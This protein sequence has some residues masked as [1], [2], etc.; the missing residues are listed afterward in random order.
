MVNDLERPIKGSV[1]LTNLVTT[2]K[3]FLCFGG[4]FL[5]FIVI[6][7]AVFLIWEKD[8]NTRMEKS[9][10]AMERILQMDKLDSVTIRVPQYQ[11]EETTSD[12]SILND[13]LQLLRDCQP[14][15][16][17]KADVQPSLF[18]Q[19]K[20]GTDIYTLIII[21]SKKQVVLDGYVYTCKL[22]AYTEFNYLFK[23]IYEMNHV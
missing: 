5:L 13:V 23:R 8:C 3:W 9:K 20:K 7:L 18:V 4:I 2:K 1:Y 22:Q 17:G 16:T 19:L 12:A 6:F 21:P 11:D 15:F 10:Q 14:E